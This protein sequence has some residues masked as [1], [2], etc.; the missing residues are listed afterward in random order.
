MNFWVVSLPFRSVPT[1]TKARR[2][3]FPLLRFG[4]KMKRNETKSEA[5]GRGRSGPRREKGRQ[6]LHSPTHPRRSTPI[7]LTAA[8][9]SKREREREAKRLSSRSP[10]SAPPHNYSDPKLSIPPLLFYSSSTRRRPRRDGPRASA[11]GPVARSGGEAEGMDPEK[12]GYKFRILFFVCLR[13]ESCSWVHAVLG[14]I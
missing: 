11:R 2:G 1:A 8:T 13:S 9:A 3:T 7:L 6:K 12:R 14:S 4:T 10:P 5:K